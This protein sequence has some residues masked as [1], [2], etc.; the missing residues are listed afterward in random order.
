MKLII[1]SSLFFSMSASASVV[2]LKSFCDCL[3]RG[4]IFDLNKEREGLA[5]KGLTA[6]IAL[7]GEAGHDTK[8]LMISRVHSDQKCDVIVRDGKIAEIRQ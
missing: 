1:L 3:K 2:L 6:E 8:M 5:S 4:Q 7:A